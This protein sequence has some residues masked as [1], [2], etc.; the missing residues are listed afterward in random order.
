MRIDRQGWLVSRLNISNRDPNNAP[1][2]AKS[3]GIMGIQGYT[4]RSEVYRFGPNQGS[5]NGVRFLY[6][7]YFS[8]NRASISCSSMTL[9]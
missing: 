9:M 4:E 8:P 3:P 1:Q 6:S 7:R 2:S 5:R